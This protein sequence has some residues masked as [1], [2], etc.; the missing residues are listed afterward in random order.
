MTAPLN[1]RPKKTAIKIPLPALIMPIDQATYQNTEL[2]FDA[3]PQDRKPAFC[4]A[5]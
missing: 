1:V 5:C 4:Q 3:T 2:K